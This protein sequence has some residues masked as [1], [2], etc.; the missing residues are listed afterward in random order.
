MAHRS[1]QICGHRIWWLY[2]RAPDE[3]ALSQF[4]EDERYG[5]ER[6]NAELANLGLRRMFLHAATLSFT[7]PDNGAPFGISLPLPEELRRLLGKLAK[8]Y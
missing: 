3:K 2:R 6:F 5:S 1:S 7:W 4:P 8:R